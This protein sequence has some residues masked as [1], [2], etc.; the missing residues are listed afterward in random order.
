MSDRGEYEPFITSAH[1]AYFEPL[2]G[3]Y[4]YSYVPRVENWVVHRDRKCQPSSLMVSLI[5]AGRRQ[6]S[7]DFEYN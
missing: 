3:L 4:T 2:S 7:L 5:L 6:E 1:S